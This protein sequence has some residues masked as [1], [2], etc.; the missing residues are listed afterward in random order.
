MLELKITEEEKFNRFIAEVNK[1]TG[2]DF[3]NNYELAK[4]LDFDAGNLSRI[5]NKKRQLPDVLIYK[6]CELFQLKPGYFF[7]RDPI[8][9][10]YNKKDLEPA[11]IKQTLLQA[12]EKQ[13][14]FTKLL[15]DALKS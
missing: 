9:I 3:P 10:S 7:G 13:K 14:E 4:S 2:V 8:L 5:L 15:Q 1:R 11:N 6:F 12:L